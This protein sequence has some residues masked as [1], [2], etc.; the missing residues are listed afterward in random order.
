MADKEITT[1]QALK[2]F[3]FEKQSENLSQNTLNTYTQHIS[4]FLDES[5]IGVGSASEITKKDYLWFMK[6]LQEDEAKK[7]TTVVSYCRSVRAFLYWLMDNGY[8]DPFDVVLPTAQQKPKETYTKEEMEKI[9]TPPPAHCKEKTY[10]TW[11]FINVVAATGLRLSSAMNLKVKDIDFSECKIY[12]CKTKNHKALTIPMTHNKEIF[13]ILKTYIRKFKL[14][15][16]DY[17]FSKPDGK[18][19]S[20]HTMQTNVIQYNRE[21][22]IEKTSI[23]LFRHTFAKDFYEQTKDIYTLQQILGHADISTTQR[24]IQSL[25]VSLFESSNYNPQQR[26]SKSNS[27]RR[28]GTI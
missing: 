15:N 21:R 17:L 1:E 18:Q 4:L 20:N 9:L 3:L 22:G 11:V 2:D 13:K 6:D 10:Y 23:H 12:V 26:Y 7:D 5:P 8:T 16:D 24:Y 27:S 28:R 19:L 14:K 25:G